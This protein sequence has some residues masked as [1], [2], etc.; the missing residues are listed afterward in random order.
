MAKTTSVEQFQVSVI[1]VFARS[2]EL[3]GKLFVAQPCDLNEKSF[4]R[5]VRNKS[6]INLNFF[7]DFYEQIFM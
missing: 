7:A 5:K 2:N 6:E 1:K 3:K 4:L